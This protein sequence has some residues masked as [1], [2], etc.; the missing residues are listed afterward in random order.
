MPLMTGCRTEADGITDLDEFSARILF[1]AGASI[2]GWGG[3]SAGTIEAD[4]LRAKDM[5]KADGCRVVPVDA[6]S[7]PSPVESP[8]LF[9]P[10][11]SRLEEAYCHESL[12]SPLASRTSTSS[13]P[14]LSRG[15]PRLFLTT[16]SLRLPA[17]LRA[18]GSLSGSP[19][20]GSHSWLFKSPAA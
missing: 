19:A 8:F 11:E 10:C 18:G 2:T 6:M 9:L 15:N 7:L 17:G 12:F 5:E 14:V 13:A 1:T 16:I 20:T 4:I 3:A